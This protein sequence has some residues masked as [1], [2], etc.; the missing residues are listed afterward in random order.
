MQNP[1]CTYHLTRFVVSDSLCSVFLTSLSFLGFLY[2]FLLYSFL[3]FFRAQVFF[4]ER[5]DGENEEVE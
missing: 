4:G 5:V 2:Y 3:F 1:K